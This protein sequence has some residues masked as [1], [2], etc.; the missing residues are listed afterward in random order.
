MDCFIVARLAMTGE[1]EQNP[2]ENNYK[3]DL[4]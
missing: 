1:K 4:L 3:K 2:S